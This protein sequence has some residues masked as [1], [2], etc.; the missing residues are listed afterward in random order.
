MNKLFL[1][2]LISVLAGSETAAALPLQH[3]KLHGPQ[4]SRLQVEQVATVANA[5]QMALAPDGTLFVGTFRAGRVWALR[6]LDKDG[7][8]EQRYL[9]AKGLNMPT[10]IAFHQG[11]LYIAAVSQ[12]LR[13]PGI[14][15]RLSQPPAPQPLPVSL[16]EHNHHGWKYLRVG[17]DGQLY[18]NVGA[19]CNIC[20]SQNPQYAALLR[21]PLAGGEPE[22][23]AHGVRNSVGFDWDSDGALWFSDN[24]R[25]MM[26]DDRPDDELNRLDTPGQHFGYPFLHANNLKDPIFGNRA[27]ELYRYTLPK[28]LL[29]AHVAPLGIHFYR[30]SSVPGLNKQSLLV[31]E[32]GSWNRSS[33]VG[34]RIIKLQIEGTEV[35]SQQLLLDG[36]L[37]GQRY[38]GRP[39]DIIEDQNGHLLISDDH[40]GAIY[41]LSGKR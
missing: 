24:G 10:G 40:A 38:W 30:G 21:L 23:I 6:D 1:P 13:L 15:N 41:R 33:K 5:R 20:L 17:P 29:G 18:F 34:Y 35:V 7:E 32:H 4:A 19:P 27:A 36:W 2:L 37:Q 14:L 39:V 22:V 16:P 12:I 8:Y 28:A 3:L 9:L 26:G 31:A 25:D 11:D